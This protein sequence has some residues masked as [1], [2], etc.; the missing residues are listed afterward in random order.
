[1]KGVDIVNPLRNL[2][3]YGQS[4]WMDNLTRGMM[5]SGELQRR[6]TEQGLR[7]ITSNPAIVH[8]AI[9]GSHDYDRH[10]AELI[11]QGLTSSEIY[12][13]L[14]VT[15]VQD[16]CDLLR[17]VY[18]ASEGLDGFVSLE[19]SPYLAHDTTGT[20]QETRRLAQAV[21]RPNVLIKIPGTPAGVPA[22]E[23]M[24]YEGININ[25][26]LL[27]AIKD[28]EAVAQAYIAA[29][30]RRVSAGQ[31]VHNVASVA[32]L[33]LSRI[34]VLVDQLLRHRLPTTT[35][36]DGRLH[37]EQCMGQAAISNAKLAYQRFKQM[38]RGP[39]W[40][41][42][43]QRGAR[44]QRLLWASTSTK[45]PHDRDV[46][47]I[48]PLIG[49][50]TV[51]TM[52]AETIAAFADHGVI[53][54]NAVEADLEKAQRV[55]HDLATVGIVFDCVTWHLQNEGIQKFMDPF[56]TLLHTLERRRQ[57]LLGELTSHEAMPCG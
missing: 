29:L 23:Q 46:R 47:Y 32:S 40:E 8:Q 19:V 16:A 7:G 25:V 49:L 43:E 52:T 30:E 20:M 26:T 4:Y 42:L 55:L 13:Q 10:I 9:S 28:Y 27:F 2:I 54:A 33:F 3:T 57:V 22:I 31:P 44:V 1:M 6:V 36:G 45:N 35:A 51:T 48:E 34:D 41:A 5:T 14:V 11:S 53:V 12:E 21:H 15:D 39:R 17:P 56:D 18:E 24:V 37:P 38:F 50:Q